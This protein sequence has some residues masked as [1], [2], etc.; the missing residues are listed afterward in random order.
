M[1]KIRNNKKIAVALSSGVDSSVASYL[2]MKQGYDVVGI[3]LKLFDDA[4][5][6]K[7]T[8]EKAKHICEKFNVEHIVIDAQDEFQ[9]TIEDYFASE[10]LLGNTPNPCVLCNKEIKWKLL[11]NELDK[12]GIQQFATGHY[13]KKILN[14]KNN[15]YEIHKANDITKDQSYFLWKL[16]QEDLARTRF[17]LSDIRKEKIKALA[18]KLNLFKSEE[19]ESQDICFVQNN[20]YR[21]F[22]KDNYNDDISKIQKGTFKN[23]EGK[24]LGY[25]DG[26]YNFTIGQRRGLDVAVGHRIYVKKILPKK[27]EVILAEKE[28]LLSNACV[29][30]D[31]N[32]VSIPQIE[33]ELLVTI[34]IRYRHKGIKAK[35]I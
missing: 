29:L 2:L 18:K 28:G 8:V 33:N 4:N 17:P 11:I 3:T 5:D 19:S 1:M 13:V 35:L 9:K 10:Y 30:K 6:K 22:L 26:Y 24:I 34:K 15:R 20:D 25:H 14:E 27:N 31:V 16:S 23:E 32:F 7:N 12:I 21:Q